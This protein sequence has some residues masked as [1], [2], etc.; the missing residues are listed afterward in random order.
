MAANELGPTYANAFNRLYAHALQ[1]Q[2]PFRRGVLYPGPLN[3][4]QAGRVRP[5]AL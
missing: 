3:V 5:I 1:E 4:D 2:L